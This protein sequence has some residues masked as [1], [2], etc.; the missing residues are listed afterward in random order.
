MRRRSIPQRASSVAT[1]TERLLY[2]LFLCLSRVYLGK[3][4]N[5]LYK[6]AQRKA[7]FLTS[8]DEM[9]SAISS[10]LGAS[11]STRR[12]GRTIPAAVAVF[13][14]EEEEAEDS[15]HSGWLSRSRCRGRPCSSTVLHAHTTFHDHTAI[16]AALPP[17]T[18]RSRL[19][20]NTGRWPARLQDSSGSSGSR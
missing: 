12:P 10:R 6:M 5:C 11:C 2:Q 17:H 8:S 18:T 20:Q 9:G 1:C 16:A 7:L 4:T 3:M 14:S 13:G 15:N 19:A